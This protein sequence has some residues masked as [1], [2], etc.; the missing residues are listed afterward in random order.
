MDSRTV[1]GKK[2]MN[3]IILNLISSFITILVSFLIIPIITNFMSTADVGIATSFITLKNILAIICLLSVEKSI[4]RIILDYK[5]KDYEQLSSILIISTLSSIMFYLLYFV[6]RGFINRILGFSTPMMSLMFALVTIINGANIFIA[7]CNYKNKYKTTFIYNVLSSP[8][9]QIMSL[10]LVYYF[11]SKKYLGRIIGLDFFPVIM[12]IIFGYLILYRGKFTYNKKYIRNALII[13]IP[14][15]PHMLSQVL[16]S[17]CDLLMIKNIIGAS[18]AGIYSIAYTLSN[19]LYL[20]LLQLQKP[21]SP[22]VYRRINNNEIDSINKNSSILISFAAILTVGL[23]TVAPDA[24]SLFLNSDY[25]PARFIIAPICVGIFFQ[26][27]YILFYD[28]EYYHKKNKEIA[29]YSII[30]AIINIILNYIFINKYGYFAAAY[31]TL[32]SYFILTLLHYYGVKR[33][34]KRNFY[35]IK[36]FAILSIIV[37]LLSFI[38]VHFISNIIVRY[39]ICFGFMIFI[40][41]LKRKDLLPFLQLFRNKD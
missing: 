21:W 4:D 32:I 11:S 29:I 7:Y 28:I 18:E 14:L 24:I 39:S 40:L 20:I 23:F 41:V 2:T 25:L 12:G 1:D 22:W 10:V 27:M 8:I 30:T 35:N 38:S 19:I 5:N 31:T 26:I 16:L 9:A 17:N 15:I 37:V 36:Y 34:E 3:S 6:F 33:I 13:S